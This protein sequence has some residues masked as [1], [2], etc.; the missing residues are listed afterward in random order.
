S[1]LPRHHEDTRAMVSCSKVVRQMSRQRTLIKGNENA[2][3][4]LGP[5]QEVRV[6]CA[7]QQV[8][9]VANAHCIQRIQPARVVALDQLPQ[10]AALI[11]VEHEAK[12]HPDQ[13][14]WGKR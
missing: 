5:S 7:K 14:P 1:A 8:G 13:A 6:L 3:L 9:Q 2:I 10:D 11:L 12:G 4:S